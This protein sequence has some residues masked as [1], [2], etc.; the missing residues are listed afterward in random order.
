[1]PRGLTVQS[2]KEKPSRQELEAAGCI[3]FIV[4]KQRDINS[5]A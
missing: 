4:R 2:S 3:T 5:N 1:M